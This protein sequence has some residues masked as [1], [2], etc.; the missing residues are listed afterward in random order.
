MIQGTLLSLGDIISLSHV[1]GNAFWGK[2][3][4]VICGF[5]NENRNNIR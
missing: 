4:Y 3:W 2:G 5:K 1:K